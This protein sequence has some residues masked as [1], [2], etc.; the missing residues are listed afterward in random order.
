MGRMAGANFAS[1][2]G[3]LL[4]AVPAAVGLCYA[5]RPTE[6]LLS[7]MRPLTLMAVFSS[8]CGFVLALT[9]GFNMV[10]RMQGPALDIARLAAG[11]AEGLAR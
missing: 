5:L 6:R 11:V 2:F 8:L 9:S 3:L 7:L 4:C 1:L 10:S